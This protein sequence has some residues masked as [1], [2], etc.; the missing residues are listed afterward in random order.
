M[1]LTLSIFRNR[2]KMGLSNMLPVPPAAEQ[3][4][5]FRAPRALGSTTVVPMSRQIVSLSL[6]LLVRISL[7]SCTLI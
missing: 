1:R 3:R 7:G 6:V 4:S 2:K 5:S